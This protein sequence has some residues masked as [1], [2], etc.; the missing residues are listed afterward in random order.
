MGFERALAM[1]CAMLFHW[2]VLIGAERSPSDIELETEMRDKMKTHFFLSANAGMRKLVYDT[3]LPC[4]TFVFRDQWSRTM[5][6]GIAVY[7]AG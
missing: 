2:Y 1:L 4:S 6:T 5:Q 3:E 7:S